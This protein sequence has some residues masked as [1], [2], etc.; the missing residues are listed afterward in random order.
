MQKKE[1]GD[2]GEEL[3]TRY[4]AKKGYAILARK[5]RVAGGEIDIIAMKGGCIAFCEVKTRQ[6]RLYGAPSEAVTLVK[7]QRL[8]R[9][10]ET[11]LYR[12]NAAD[13]SCRFDVI[14]VYFKNMA[15]FR[16]NH[17]ES[18]FY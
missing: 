14:E 2:I 9:A 6:S 15:E 3:A 17:I 7:Q 1:L 4:L 12:E 8:R 18:A 16:I 10:A 13:V 11:Y 5:Y